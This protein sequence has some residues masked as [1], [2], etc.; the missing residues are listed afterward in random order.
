MSVLKLLKTYNSSS[1]PERN[2]ESAPVPLLEHPFFRLSYTQKCL[3]SLGIQE[4]SDF[5]PYHSSSEEYSYLYLEEAGTV[6]HCENSLRK[7]WEEEFLDFQTQGFPFCLWL[8]GNLIGLAKKPKKLPQTLRITASH[9]EAISEVAGHILGAEYAEL[10]RC[11]PKLPPAMAMDR[12]AFYLERAGLEQEGR[13]WALPSTLSCYGEEGLLYV[14]LEES[15]KQI[16][17]SRWY[18]QDR[19]H[20][21]S[22]ITSY[23]KLGQRRSD[24]FTSPLYPRMQCEVQYGP[25]S[26]C[27]FTGSEGYSGDVRALIGV[28]EILMKRPITLKI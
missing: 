1:G 23:D 22:W 21:Y 10:L 28:I 7:E 16:I 18:T 14:R 11:L 27:T 9:Q 19:Q 13:F 15:S 12:I 25:D 3:Y 8:D 6:V 24:R 5:G 26:I 17:E 4:L 20:V 2:Q